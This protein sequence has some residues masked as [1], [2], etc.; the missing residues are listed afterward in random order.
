MSASDKAA[1]RSSAHVQALWIELAKSTDKLDG[2]SILVRATFAQAAIALDG[3]IF[4]A[5]FVA[6]SR[7]KSPVLLE[8]P[9][10]SD[11]E[12]VNRVRATLGIEPMSRLQARSWHELPGL[13]VLVAHVPCAPDWRDRLKVL[14]ERFPRA[15]HKIKDELRAATAK[16]R[17]SVAAALAYLLKNP[18]ATDVE[19]AEAANVTTRALRASPRWRAAREGQRELARREARDRHPNA[20][21]S[22]LSSGLRIRRNRPK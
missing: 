20:E 10:S 22:A 18:N 12:S 19:A 6:K 2:E 21:E 14:V 11:E 13:L 4:R 17:G 8:S 1:H 5:A 15:L 3:H 7:R 9:V 16:P